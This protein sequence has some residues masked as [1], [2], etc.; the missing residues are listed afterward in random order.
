MERSPLKV[1]SK[2]K[3]LENAFEN[4]EFVGKKK[5]RE[6]IKF[7]NQRMRITLQFRIPWFIP[8]LKAFPI[9]FHPQKENKKD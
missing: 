5:I 6:K 9:I 1:F 8:F 4:K 2:I 3:L 7:I